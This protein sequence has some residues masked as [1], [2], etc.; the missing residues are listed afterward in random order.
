MGS[1]CLPRSLARV[2]LILAITLLFTGCARKA[3]E[4]V[5]FGS[6]NGSIYQNK[7][8]GFSIALPKD[9]SVQDQK[10]QQGL[11]KKG[12]QLVSGD[13]ENL[14]T[15][16]KVSELRTVNLLAAFEHPIGSPV[17]Y[18]PS[19]VSVAESVRDLPGIKRGKDYL[20]QARKMLE[21]GQISVSFPRDYY[22]ER[23]GGVEFD[24]LDAEISVM[25]K[26]V[27]QKYY[28]TIRKGYAVNFILSFTNEEEA[29]SLQ[30]I[31]DSLTFQ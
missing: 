31:L 10:A 4:E 23:M 16:A 5:D 22:T 20:Y 13:D 7:Y 11:S 3:S 9:W 28:A 2:A 27:K 6:M 21:A 26:S 29:A 1:I 14:K 24:V 25:R 30:K 15:M 17:D 19:I 18:N 12:V 8:F